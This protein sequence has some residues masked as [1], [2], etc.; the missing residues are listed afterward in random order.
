MVQWVQRGIPEVA[1]HCRVA[2][3]QHFKNSQ[4]TKFWRKIVDF[5]NIPSQF[6]EI[7]YKFR[8]ILQQLWNIFE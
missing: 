4:D 3:K 8:D 7:P 2:A 5:R 1:I 6:R